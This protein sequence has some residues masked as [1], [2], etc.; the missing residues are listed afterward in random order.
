MERPHT[1]APESTGR[2]VSTKPVITNKSQRVFLT[3]G[4]KE[5]VLAVA[6][7]I[8]TFLESAKISQRAIKQFE[9]IEEQLTK[10]LELVVDPE[11]IDDEHNLEGIANALDLIAN[12][13]HATFD[14][15][16]ETT[17]PNCHKTFEVEIQETQ[18]I[19]P[20]V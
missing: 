4:D 10:V 20:L 8:R 1:P 16:A 9:R 3:T 11:R 6:R 5:V 19:K 17:C 18:N 12:W 15:S 7:D 13:S 14:G 2:D